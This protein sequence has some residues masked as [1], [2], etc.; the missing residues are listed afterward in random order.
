MKM[1]IKS[2][3]IGK[4][5]KILA[6]NNFIN[7]NDVDKLAQYLHVAISNYY[8]LS[9]KKNFAAHLKYSSDFNDWTNYF[10]ILI[11]N[12]N[13]LFNEDIDIRKEDIE[14]TI[15]EGGDNDK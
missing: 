7:V 11:I 12:F 6:N 15:I 4:V 13:F 2:Q 10:K 3:D 14:I 1:I 9:L 5:A 8:I